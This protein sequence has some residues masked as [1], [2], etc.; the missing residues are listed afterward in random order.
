MLWSCVGQ[1]LLHVSGQTHN[2]ST[3]NTSGQIGAS[4]SVEVQARHHPEQDLLY[5]LHCDERGVCACE[6]LLRDEFQHSHEVHVPVAPVEPRIAEGRREA[7]VDP[8]MKL[9]D[10][11]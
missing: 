1:R 7:H 2:E 8:E 9:G 6:G 10:L 4:L 5:D 11:M 3:K